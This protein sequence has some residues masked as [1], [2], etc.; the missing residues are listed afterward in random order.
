MLALLAKGLP[1]ESLSS[2]FHFPRFAPLP[3]CRRLYDFPTISFF[4]AGCESG[5]TWRPFCSLDYWAAYRIP[6]LADD[7]CCRRPVRLCLHLIS[8][9]F[10]GIGPGLPVANLSFTA[11]RSFDPT[12]FCCPFFP[13]RCFGRHRFLSPAAAVAWSRGFPP[14]FCGSPGSFSLWAVE[15]PS[16]PTLRRG[17]QCSVFSYI[18]WC[19]L[20]ALEGLSGAS[21]LQTPRL[22]TEHG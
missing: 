20:P 5:P 21:A 18:L 13:P 12:C 16:F 10:P 2:S 8:P 4:R 7:F 3:E 14:L 1:F 19:R 22:R 9:F 15:I 11:P 6:P 17:C